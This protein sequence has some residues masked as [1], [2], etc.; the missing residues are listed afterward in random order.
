MFNKVNHSNWLAYKVRKEVE[1]LLHTH[2]YNP[3]FEELNFTYNIYQGVQEA[4]GAKEPPN[5]SS[6]HVVE[7][8][9]I[10]DGIL[11]D[12]VGKKMVM[13]RAVSLPL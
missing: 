9:I 12:Q 13:E 7:D 3:S 10:V 8:Q 5:P 2:I 4:N 6:K 1:L 11:E